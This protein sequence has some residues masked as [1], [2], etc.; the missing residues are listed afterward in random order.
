MKNTLTV[1]GEYANV[2]WVLKILLAISRVPTVYYNFCINFTY[3]WKWIT[4]FLNRFANNNLKIITTFW[5]FIVNITVVQ[6]V[7]VTCTSIWKSFWN[8]STKGDSN[9]ERLTDVGL[10]LRLKVCDHYLK[11]KQITVYC[12]LFI[13]I[14]LYWLR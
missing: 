2:Q 8:E 1:I 6:S 14:S 9:H 13:Q 5:I 7:H 4:K 3:I 10:T 12:F 11:S